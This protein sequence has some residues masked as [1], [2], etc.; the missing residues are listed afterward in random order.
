LTDLSVSIVN[1]TSREL[2]LACLETLPRD[3]DVVVLDNASEDGSADAVREHFPDV[4]V[5]A[6]DFRAGF[7]ANHNTVIRATDGRYVYVLNEDTTS[8]DWAFERIVAYLDA[9]PR[10]AALGPRV[11]YPDGRQQASAWRFPT[12][13]VSA[14][15]LL[16]VGK[17]G[18]TQSHGEDARPVDWV[19]GAALVLRREALEE[20]GLFDEEFFLYS[21]E[22][23]LQFRLHQ[24]GWEVHYLP[25][26]TVVHHESQF[27]AEIPERRINEM[28]RSRHRYWRKHHSDAGARVAA[29]AT[30]AQYAVRAVAAP[31]AHR[32]RRRML[33]H[34]RDAWRVDGPGLRELADEWNGRVGS[35]SRG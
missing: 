24:A 29:V 16:T 34:A 14:I 31:L 28:W 35:S 32:S 17:L 20:V 10:V 5:L 7:G 33:L 2:L 11:V 3:A 15:G 9:H 8:G 30:G 23:D 27:S 12:P 18:V 21:E 22:V 6:Q 13:L 4:R 26:A 25:D 1:T 19:T